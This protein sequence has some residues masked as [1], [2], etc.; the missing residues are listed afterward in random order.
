[1]TPH[2]LVGRDHQIGVVDE[3]L[4]SLEDGRG[5]ALLITGEPGIG[6]TRL[7]EEIVARAAARGARPA[8][9][10]APQV[11]APALWMWS[12]VLR[13]LRGSAAAIE[14]PVH[15][16]PDEADSARFAQFEA[17]A[18]AV[19][20]AT[21]KKPVLVVLDDLQWAD[22]ASR[23]LLAFVAAAVRDRPALFVGTLRPAELPDEEV[24]ALTRLGTTIALGGLDAEAVHEVLKMA[25]GHEVATEVGN[26]VNARSG[27]NPLFVWEFG[28]LMNSSG[29]T[30]VAAA[31]I[32]PAVA[33]VIGRRLARLSED[34]TA[35]LHAAAV[36][37]KEFSVELVEWLTTAIATTDEPN[38][39]NL[40]ERLAAAEKAGVLLK[41]SRSGFAF[42]HDLIREVVA[43]TTPPARRAA[44]HAAAA[45]FYRSRLSRDPSLHAA[46]A[47]NLEQADASG[48]AGP[49]WE[50]AA[51]W[52][53]GLLSYEQ[54]AVYF[55]RAA[56]AAEADSDRRVDLLL[57]EA[58]ARMRGGELGQAR[59]RF[60][61]A[62]VMARLA[63]LPDRMA[64]AALGIGAGVAG[65]EVP[66]WDDDHN[67]LLEAALGCQPVDALGTRSMLLARLS[68]GG[69]TPDTQRESARLAEEAVALARQVGE[70]RLIAQ[71]LAALCDA[72]GGPDHISTRR[73]YA[74]TIV[75]L[76]DQAGD[77]VL[78]LLGRRFLIVSALEL[79]DFATVDREIAIFERLAGQLRQPLLSW[80]G[81]LFR[82]MRA[83][84]RGD[85]EQA[86]ARHA[87]VA[88]AAVRTGSKNAEMLAATLSLG[89]DV[90]LGRPSP[91]SV[92]E[93]LVDIDPDLWGSYAAGLGFIALT[94]GDLVRAEQ[95][96][97]P[98]S[99]DG[100]A[101]VGRD[102]EYLA[103][104]SLFARVA[105]SV[106]QSAVAERLYDLLAPY[107]G[108][109]LVDGIG[110]MCWGPVDLELA[111]LAAYLGRRDAAAV[112]LDAARAAVGAADAPGLQGDLDD[113]AA[114]LGAT[115]VP[116]Q[117]RTGTQNE[118]RVEGQFWTLHFNGQTVRMKNAKGLHDISRLLSSPRREIHVVDLYGDAPVPKDVAQHNND[119]GDVLDAGARAAYRNRLVEVEEDIA[120]AEAASDLG[121]L[122][123]AQRERDFL[124]AELAAAL[125]LGGRAR[126]AGATHERARKA[127]STRIKLA[128]DRIDDAH[129]GLAQHLRHS[130]RT[131]VF[132]SYQPER[133][134]EWLL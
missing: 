31:A 86:E 92:M 90:A 96:M 5:S 118:W 130:I 49:H 102:S 82:G 7:A 80:Y 76:A 89:I 57:A 126:R 33:A 41:T 26:A 129:P 37:G 56:G 74:Q 32:P 123:K 114:G 70:P 61:E 79:G 124:A 22:A 99:S 132:C 119:L 10:T 52:A 15:T 107:A 9:A 35:S 69:A 121:R 103:T 46:V 55:E 59:A 128:V 58:D 27:G 30:E 4:A 68:V 98:H 117:K 67:K 120:E 60:A 88:D 116:V 97:R 104:L 71:A 16:T 25:S 34:V 110:A 40:A 19:R 62:A 85:L 113:I 8:W 112:H 54:A 48:E 127:V 20:G 87:E 23:R 77:R 111:R 29:R 64:T 81:P 125:G 2:R 95:L 47:T 6:K 51:R 131:G 21:N 38:A 1:M 101:R 11:G 73:S 63:G 18:A 45:D 65:W 83:Q 106:D 12:E 109:W 36:A 39:E 133:K 84:M 14:P 78:S 13:Q 66:I 43:D 42:A 50:A 122:D 94:N 93:G 28:R 100:F 91:L 75:E 108:L 53:L 3:L 115:R 72:M 44:L 24:G 17:V 134:T 105:T